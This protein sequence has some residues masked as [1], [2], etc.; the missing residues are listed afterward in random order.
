MTFGGFQTSWGKAYRYFPLKTTFLISLFIFEIGSLICGVAPNA[1]ALI[2]GR[3]IAGLGGV[4]DDLLPY[5]PLPPPNSQTDVAYSYAH[6][7]FQ[8]RNQLL[9]FS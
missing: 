8:S 7:N 4:C 3:A 1:N 9:H 5:F 2:V 6:L